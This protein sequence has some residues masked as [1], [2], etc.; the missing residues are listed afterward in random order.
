MEALKLTFLTT[1]DGEPWAVFAYG[2]VEP[3]L[4]SR[5]M[6]IEAMNH[7][8]TDDGDQWAADNPEDQPLEVKQFW[9]SDINPHADKKSRRD[10]D[11][12]DLDDGGMTAYFAEAGHDGA[13]P[14][15]GLR[16]L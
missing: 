9:L 7:H 12:A 15:T 16:L 5:A 1:E 13:Y 10:D 6:I 3:G 8:G 4:I 2:H 14:V 11:D